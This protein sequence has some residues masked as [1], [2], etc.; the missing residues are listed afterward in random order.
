M[1]L[2][3]HPEHPGRHYLYQTWWL[4]LRAPLRLNTPKGLNPALFQ[5]HSLSRRVALLHGR[6]NKQ[7]AR[8]ASSLPAT[9]FISLP[10]TQITSCLLCIDP[11][12][13]WP[14]EDMNWHSANEQAR[15]PWSS[16]RGRHFQIRVEL[17]EWAD[18][19]SGNSAHLQ[20][21]HLETGV[22]YTPMFTSSMIWAQLM[23]GWVQA[24]AVDEVRTALVKPSLTCT[25]INKKENFTKKEEIFVAS[26]R[27]TRISST[28]S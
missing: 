5:K 26:H 10:H 14:I 1:D 18:L 23:R 2:G 13:S 17:V 27:L 3:K 8:K 12:W 16:G 24:D 9:T 28:L 11:L 22:Y 20:K 25:E 15:A 21:S 6:T 7:L 19:I 4:Q